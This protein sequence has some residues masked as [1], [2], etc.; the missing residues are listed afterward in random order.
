VA[1]VLTDV[2][3][4][5]V[6]DKL[7]ETVQTE[8]DYIAWGSGAGTADKADTTLFTEETESRVQGTGSQP[9]ADKLRYVGTLTA[10]G[11]KTI[12]NAGTFTAS[13]G[14]TLVVKGDF[15]GIPLE[16]NDQIEFTIDLEI[17]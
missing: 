16:L 10:D 9:V 7:D 4:G 2:G 8:A 1:T 3:E 12:T 5:W 14:G 13:T 15:T 11:T 6:V 17:T